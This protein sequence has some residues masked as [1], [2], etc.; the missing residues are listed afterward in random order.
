MLRMG[1]NPK[2]EQAAPDKIEAEPSPSQSYG[3]HAAAATPPAP[4]GPPSYS[5][6]VGNVAAQPRPAGEK[7]AA[8]GRAVSESE[9][10]ARDIKD[11]LV[12]GFVGSGTTLTGEANFKGMLRIDGHL[13]GHVSS[14]KG[15]LIVSSGGQVDANVEVAA[16]KIN[17]VVN[18]DIIASQRIEM[19][20]TAHVS[21]NIQ[22]P[23]L[24]I[25]QGAIFE[26]SCRMARSQ[27]PAATESREALAAPAERADEIG[28]ALADEP[29][30]VED[31]ARL[32]N[33]A[34]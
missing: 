4:S 5:S 32:A 12:T 22:T 1:R 26:G 6:G 16:A 31:P 11:G 7:P 34:R 28:L 9:S 8:T 25:E 14:E 20:R 2:T 33:A 15:T 18:G 13:S 21:G 29:A 17:G 24:V 3:S 30:A 19:G 23:I 10:L 27:S